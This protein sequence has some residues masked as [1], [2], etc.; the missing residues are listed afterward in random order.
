MTYTTKPNA[1]REQG[2]K[3][4]KQKR[5]SKQYTAKSTSSEAQRQRIIEALR[6]GPKTSYQLRRLGCYQ[7]STRIF[8]LRRQGYD[9]ETERVVLYDR[10]GF[11]HPR[12]ARYHLRGEA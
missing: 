6:T 11:M 1:L 10:D 2:V 9:I 3:A 5:Q 12:C 7:H 4:A 8:E